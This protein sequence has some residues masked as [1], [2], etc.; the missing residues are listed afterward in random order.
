MEEAFKIQ[1]LKLVRKLRDIFLGIARLDREAFASVYLK[2]SGIEIGAL[3]DPL[4]VPRST[5]VQYVDRMTI[6][7]LRRHYPE[8]K[9]RKLVNVDILDNGETLGTIADASQYFVIANHFLE[10]CEDPIRA[11]I[12]FTRVL[13]DS[14][15]LFLTVPDK[16]FTFDKYR[17]ITPFDH[18]VIDY[19]NGPVFSRNEHFRDWVVNVEGQKD[20]AIIQQRVNELVSTSYSI[21]FHCWTQEEM[22]EFFSKLNEQYNLHLEIQLFM[23]HDGEAI[24]IIKKYV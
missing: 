4:K 20:E 8:L 13:R 16:R 1:A 5:K 21:H 6:P 15:I 7:D 9:N 3:W 19:A 24:F 23:K 14:G 2:G 10:H 18:L 12:N 11:M 17:Q 22:F